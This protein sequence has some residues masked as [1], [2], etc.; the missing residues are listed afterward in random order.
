[1]EMRDRI[2]RL[3]NEIVHAAACSGAR[4]V[5]IFGSVA[6]GEERAD[7]DVDFLVSLEANRT[8]LDLAR[9]EIALER[10][11]QRPV[12]VMTEKELPPL[13]REIAKREAIPV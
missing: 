2:R 12:E 11:L 4:D 9:L 3:R 5:R 7:S 6:R 8:L 13:V 10:L 1:M